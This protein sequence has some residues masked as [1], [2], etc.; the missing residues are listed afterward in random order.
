M[1]RNPP[2]FNPEKRATRKDEA[3]VKA[4]ALCKNTAKCPP[5]AVAHEDT[6]PDG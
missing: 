3:R 6:F 4:D 5:G 1:V 2:A